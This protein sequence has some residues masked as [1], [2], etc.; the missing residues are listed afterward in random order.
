ME[1]ELAD[2]PASERT[3]VQAGQERSSEDIGNDRSVIPQRFS[4]ASAGN[5]LLAAVGRTQTVG[6]VRIEREAEP[7]AE[8]E[9]VTMSGAVVRVPNIEPITNIFTL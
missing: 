4:I 5:A 1:K 2:Y 3:N 6:A 8:P 9:V 7:H